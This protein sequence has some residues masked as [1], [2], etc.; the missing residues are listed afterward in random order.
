MNAGPVYIGYKRVSSVDQNSERQLD[1]PR[2]Q[3]KLARVFEDKASGKD[4]KRPGFEA[5]MGHL[6]EGDILVVHSMD[7]LCRNLS[8]LLATVESLNRRGIGVWFLKENLDFKA[9]EAADA[10]S[11]LLLGVLGACAE[12][13]R[14]LIRERQ[15]EGIAIAK[16][17]GLYKGGKPK[18][19]GDDAAQIVA[20]VRAGEKVAKVARAFG[21]SRQTVYTY[22]AK[23]DDTQV[24]SK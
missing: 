20:R 13:E 14:A 21:V 16:A 9:G 10:Y 1:D 2:V 7:R 11:K 17:R 24:S 22:L 4:T 12:F 5:L 19:E 6:R 23:T 3:G 8:D 15:R 18:Y